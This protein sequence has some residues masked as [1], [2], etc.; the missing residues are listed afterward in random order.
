ML[1]PQPQ[2]TRLLPVDY[3]RIFPH[4]LLEENE[5]DRFYRASALHLL[6]LY[7]SVEA[8][9]SGLE[10]EELLEANRDKVLAPTERAMIRGIVHRSDPGSTKFEGARQT[11]DTLPG[12]INPETVSHPPMVEESTYN[13]MIENAGWIA[14]VK[15]YQ[16]LGAIDGEFS[17][18]LQEEWEATHSEQLTQKLDLNDEFQRRIY[19]GLRYLWYIQR[20]QEQGGHD[21]EWNRVGTHA[22]TVASDI[23]VKRSPLTEAGTVEKIYKPDALVDQQAA[24]DFLRQQVGMGSRFAADGYIAVDYEAALASYEIFSDS[25]VIVERKV[26]LK[27]RVASDAFLMALVYG[28]DNPLIADLIPPD[29]RGHFHLTYERCMAGEMG[30]TPSDVRGYSLTEGMPLSLLRRIN[31]AWPDDC[32]FITDLLTEEITIDGETARRDEQ[33]AFQEKVT[34]FRRLARGFP[35]DLNSLLRRHLQVLYMETAAKATTKAEESYYLV[36]DLLSE[37]YQME[38]DSS[39]HLLGGIWYE[40]GKDLT[41][42][43][44]NEYWD[45]L[46]QA[47]M[48]NPASVATLEVPPT[49]ESVTTAALPQEMV[50]YQG[51]P[52]RDDAHLNASLSW[53]MGHEFWDNGE[54]P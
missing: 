8:F 49:D 7:E 42:T 32:A 35:V 19:N 12:Y 52:P 31:G 5:V 30:R 10:Y 34:L 40:Y 46:A 37:L 13:R 33:E 21:V 18:E 1:E 51:W 45:V 17:V 39:R 36:G 3:A 22:F 53:W 20:Q 28:V 44:G 24:F 15:A 11:V 50:L 6:Y 26:A 4:D 47:L 23:L 9:P 38:H 2:D 29:L 14:A 43:L 27:Q 16:D 54:L 41:G 48:S 25:G